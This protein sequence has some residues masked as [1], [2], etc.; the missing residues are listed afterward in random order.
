MAPAQRSEVTSRPLQLFEAD[1]QRR[2]GHVGSVDLLLQD[3]SVITVIIFL[4]PIMAEL[5]T[6]HRAALLPRQHLGG[7]DA[8]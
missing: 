3:C 7:Q 4:I 2:L 1:S 5:L 8:A 6:R